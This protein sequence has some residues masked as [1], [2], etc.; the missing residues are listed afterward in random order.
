MT[1]LDYVFL[2]A[3]SDLDNREVVRDVFLSQLRIERASIIRTD[4]FRVSGYIMAYSICVVT[5]NLTYYGL[6]HWAGAWTI[7]DVVFE[8]PDITTP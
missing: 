5:S 7:D 2:A 6:M 3:I 4:V 1:D 8:P